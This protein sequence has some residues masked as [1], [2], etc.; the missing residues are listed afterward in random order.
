MAS[1]IHVAAILAAARRRRRCPRCGHKKPAQARFCPYCG[2]KELT[3][4]VPPE[5][6]NTP[7]NGPFSKLL[8]WIKAKF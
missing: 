5:A 4:T 8:G 7:T 6:L 1:P 3:Q 2:K